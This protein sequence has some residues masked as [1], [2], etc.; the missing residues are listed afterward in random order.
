M[1]EAKDI[2]PIHKVEHNAIVSMQGDMTIA[3]RATLPEIF[4]LSDREYEAYHQTWLKA[5][6]VLP[7]HSIFHKQDWF[8]AQAY[9]A[10]YEKSGGS[11]L[12]RSSE[13]F[14]NERPYLDHECYIF[15]TKKPKDRKLS[16][17]AMSNILRKTIVPEQ[18]ISPVLY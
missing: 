2:L 4:T 7:T 16:S 15:L 8:T 17:S 1:R 18:M 9:R 6:K 10:D 14:F 13:T 12:S 11:F 3:Y 5:I